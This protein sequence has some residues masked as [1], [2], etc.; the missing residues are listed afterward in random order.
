MNTS[1]QTPRA[2]VPLDRLPLTPP[3]RTPKKKPA[4]PNPDTE[5]VLREIAEINQSHAVQ[6]TP[7]RRRPLTSFAQA[8]PRPSFYLSLSDLMSMLLVFFVLIFSLSR[9]GPTTAQASASGGKTTATAAVLKDP[10]PLPKPVPRP[11]R[12]GIKAVSTPGQSD[13]GLVSERPQPQKAAKAQLN[14]RPRLR[15]GRLPDASSTNQVIDRALLTLVT[16]AAPLPRQ[17]LPS[18]ESSLSQLL[19]RLNRE[20]KGRASQGV[21]IKK[22]SDRLVLRLPEAITFDEGQAIIKPGMRRL[23][24]R[25]A[26]IMATS[27][28]SHIVVTGHTDDRPIS[29]RQFASNWELSAARAAAVARA[30]MD[31]GNDPKRF[32]IRGLADQKPRV[33]N[34]SEHNR[35]L[36]R[37]VEIELI[38]PGVPPAASRGW[39]MGHTP[40]RQK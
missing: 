18:E 23:L 34:T 13:P 11:V 17:A 38:P 24:H 8:E 5:Q 1:P 12:M 4:R 33:P 22:Q 39:R 19:S 20:V 32:T 9:P 7:R 15:P 25:L 26:R 30:L 37:R 31:Q 35:R 6:G 29:N 2:R 16:S 14:P 21:E 28:R 40:L 27:P 3:A 36:N 10:L